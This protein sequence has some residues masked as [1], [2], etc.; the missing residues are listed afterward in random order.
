MTD[1]QNNPAIADAQLIALQQWQ[2]TEIQALVHTYAE[3][4]SPIAP[5]LAYQMLTLF[6]DQIIEEPGS[7]M[8][9]NAEMKSFKAEHGKPRPEDD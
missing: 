5:P 6:V 4:G 7:V 9:L 3:K 1:D 2:L 8:D